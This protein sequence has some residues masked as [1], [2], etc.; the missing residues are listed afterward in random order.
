MDIKV[1][2]TSL[3]IALASDYN[4]LYVVD[5]QDDSYVEYA[6]SGAQKDLVPISRGDMARRSSLTSMTSINTRPSRICINGFF[7]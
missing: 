7:E 3:A 5:T 4:S 1:S 6:P 2:F